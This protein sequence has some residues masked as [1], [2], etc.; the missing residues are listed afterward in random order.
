MARQK[1]DGRGRL[2]GRA[3]GTPN[4]E[5]PLKV[6]LREH[7][8]DYFIP[9]KEEVDEAG[10]KTGRMI[11]KF[12]ED[13]SQLD[14]VSRT[15]IEV[16]LLKYHTPQMQSTSMDLTVVESNRTMSERIALL[17]AGKEIPADGE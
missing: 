8:L 1:G 16:Q 17:A 10:H 7:S 11:S 14:P 15:D 2:G 9:R 6:F 12:D 5:K 13:I 3:A 4:K